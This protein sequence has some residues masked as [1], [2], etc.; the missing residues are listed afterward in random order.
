[1]LVVMVWRPS[2]ITV[3]EQ[4]PCCTL[5]N[6]FLYASCWDDKL[7]KSIQTCRNNRHSTFCKLHVGTYNEDFLPYMFK[8]QE[9]SNVGG[10]IPILDYC[11]YVNWGENRK[12]WILFYLLVVCVKN[13]CFSQHIDLFS[14]IHGKS[15]VATSSCYCFLS[16]CLAILDTH[17]N[18]LQF[19]LSLGKL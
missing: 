16:L 18:F 2:C 6:Y 8:G 5:T 11:N 13:Y 7:T 4:S 14:N 19:P 15:G 10:I 1:M 17:A 12:F 9:R 3:W